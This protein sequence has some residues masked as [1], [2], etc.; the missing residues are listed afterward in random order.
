MLVQGL[1]PQQHGWRAAPAQQ[2]MKDSFASTVPQVTGGRLLALAHTVHVY[3]APAMSTVRHVIQRLVRRRNG[4]WYTGVSSRRVPGF[5][6]QIMVVS[7]TRE[8]KTSCYGFF[9]F[10]QKQ[11]HVTAGITQQVLTV[12]S[13]VKDI[14]VMRLQALPLTV[15]HVR[16]QEAQAVP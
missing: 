9:F 14:M 12:K 1:E 15:S 11:V 7:V 10:P 13:A 3:C 16:V 8:V 2:D 4:N 6:F 5:S